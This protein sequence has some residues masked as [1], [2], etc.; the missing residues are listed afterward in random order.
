MWQSFDS[1]PMMTELI[2]WLQGQGI[3]DAINS[4][5]TVVLASFAAVQLLQV[6]LDRRE[7]LRIAYAAAWIEYW[8]LWTISENWKQTDLVEGASR[9]L[10]LP[11][12]IRPSD[13]G[14]VLA[15]IGQL[16]QLPARFVGSAYA[17]AGTA[18]DSG[19]LLLRMTE[20]FSSKLVKATTPEEKQLVRDKFTDLLK[21]RERLTKEA[22]RQAADTFEDAL[23][24]VPKW[25]KTERV[26]LTGLSSPMAERLRV[27]VAKMKPRS[28]P[29]GRPGRWLGEPFRRIGAWLDPD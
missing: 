28:A 3:L 2:K 1:G 19:A 14:S 16:G 8:R 23:K 17:M 26:D 12:H 25:L 18:A 20:Q 4:L 24:A 27:E 13:W 7:R 9:G 11:D 6:R 5:T 21:E 22:A 15:I 29:L 10:Y